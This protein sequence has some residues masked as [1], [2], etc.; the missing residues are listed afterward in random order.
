MFLSD[1]VTLLKV[2]TKNWYVFVFY[3]KYSSFS[4][5]LSQLLLMYLEEEVLTQVVHSNWSIA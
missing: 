3:W 1:I 5:Y 2:M 4:A